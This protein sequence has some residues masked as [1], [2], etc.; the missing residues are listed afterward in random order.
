MS[1]G[2]LQYTP[3]KAVLFIKATAVLHNMCRK[4][5]LPDPDILMQEDED[6][7]YAAEPHVRPTGLNTRNTLIDTHFSD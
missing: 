7:V 5:N 2:Y 6:N 3:E 1:G 4:A